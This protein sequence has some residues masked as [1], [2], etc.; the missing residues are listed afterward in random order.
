MM[1]G[2]APSNPNLKSMRSLDY[3]S[4][5]IIT[6]RSSSTTFKNVHGILNTVSWGIL[7]LIG[8]TNA[9]NL[10]RFESADPLWFYLHVSCQLLAY[11]LGGFGGFVTGIVLGK[12][13]HGIE[14]SSYKIIG[15]A[16]FCLA[17]KQVFDGLVRPC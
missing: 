1:H 10:T 9:R 12:R 8:A 5:R 3:L 13:S 11:I 14:H 6:I 17:I 16:L 2:V 4:R 7:M 15:I